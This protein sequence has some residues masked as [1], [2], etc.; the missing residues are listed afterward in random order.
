MT[1]AG[2][3]CGGYAASVQG[4]SIRF[5]LC[6]SIKALWSGGLQPPSRLCA[7]VGLTVA[8]KVIKN[9]DYFAKNV[10]IY[11]CFDKKS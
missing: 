10:V 8:E 1:A 9:Y 7:S 5:G 11:N 3:L 4:C 2:L 6:V